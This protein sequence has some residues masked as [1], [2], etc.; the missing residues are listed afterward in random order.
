MALSG[1][2][3]KG[4][5]MI[6]KIIE[7]AVNEAVREYKAEMLRIALSQINDYFRY[8]PTRAIKKGPAN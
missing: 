6:D 1:L 2:T 5:G 4:F 8:I 3:R 7:N